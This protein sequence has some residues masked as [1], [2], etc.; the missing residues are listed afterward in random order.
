M[1][2]PVPARHLRRS[3]NSS[4]LTISAVLAFSDVAAGSPFL[5]IR[6]LSPFP[7]IKAFTGGSGDARSLSV[8]FNDGARGLTFS[9]DRAMLEHM[10]YPGG[11]NGAGVYQKIISLMPAA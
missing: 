4:I 2:S 8:E 11:K 3:L 1:W 5:T 7:T 10:S 6:T 9:P